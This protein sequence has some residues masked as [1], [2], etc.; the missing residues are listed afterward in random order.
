MKQSV[1]HDNYDDCN[2]FTFAKEGDVIKMNSAL[3][4]T[5]KVFVQLLAS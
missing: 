3:A 5:C 4:V 2:A 1:W